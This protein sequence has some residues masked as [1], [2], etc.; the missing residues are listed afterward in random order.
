M[1]PPE[2]SDLVAVPGITD[3]FISGT[4]PVVLDRGAGLEEVYNP[5]RTDAQ[6]R[7]ALVALAFDAGV[8]LDIAHPMADVVLGDKRLHMVLP[9]GVSAR[10][11]LSIR[12]HRD[13]PPSYANSELLDQLEQLV[14]ERKTLLVAGPTGAG[15][16]TLARQ[17]LSPLRERIITIEQTPELR[18]GGRAVQL[19]SREPNQEGKGG[20]TLARLVTEALRMRPDRLVIGE[21]RSEEFGAFLQAVT[22]GHP[23]AVTTLHS[24]S[25]SALARRLEILGLLSNLEPKLTARLVADCVDA[26]A[27]L[28]WRNGQ[29][30]ILGIAAPRLK[31]SQL[32]LEPLA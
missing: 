22:S 32:I 26:I 25:F 23:G 15:K 9:Y 6:L 16:T 8:R 20:V 12:V 27:Q 24:H 10:P 14:G 19:Y 7:D 21:V 30:A 1:L 4:R 18:L 31:G 5:F 3:C 11:E 13:S 2:L 17:L 29:R 28:G